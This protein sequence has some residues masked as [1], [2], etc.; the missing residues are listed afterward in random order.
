[1]SA[2]QLARQRSISSNSR[3]TPSSQSKGKGPVVT[4]PFEPCAATASLFLYAQA[5]SISCLHHDT[6]AIERRFEKHVDNVQLI[7]V[8]NVSERGAGRLVVSYDVGRTA[9]VW[10]LFSGQEIARFSSFEHITV[11]AWMRNG[12]VAFGNTKGE[13]ILFE[14][15]TSEHISAKTIYD[16]ITALAPSADCKV[17]AIGYNNGSIL[18][19]T[20]QP[21]FTILH[22]LTT[23]RA[24]SPIAALAWHA[25]SSKQKSDMLATQ[26]CDGDLRVWS[27]AKPPTGDAPRVIRA[28]RRSEN[29]SPGR[30]WISWSKN[31]RIVQYS[32]RETWSWD[33]RTKHVT[34]ET[35]PTVEE[36]RGL[37]GYGPT[38]TLFTLG[39]NHTIQQYDLE[40]PQMVANVH[41]PPMTV[42]PTPPEELNQQLGLS[43]SESEEDIP[44]PITKATRYVKTL[45][46][47]RVERAQSGSPRSTRSRTESQSSQASSTQER[48][49]KLGQMVRTDGNSTVFS[50][51]TQSQISRDPALTSSSMTYPSSIQSP[52]STKSTR[53]GSRLKQEVLPSPEERPVK[54]LFPYTRARLSDIP[55]KPPRAFDEVNLTPDDLRR[56]M[57]SVV[58]GWNE[59]IRDLIRDE[60]SHHSVGSQSSVLLSRWLDDDPDQMAS[61][62]GAG[63]TPSSLDWMMLALSGIGN[64]AQSKK[65]GQAFV[66]KMLAKG[67]IHAAATILL[68]LGDYN[69]A[70]EVYVTRNHFMEAILLTCLLM[71]QNWQ[72]VSFLVR[73][74]GKHV[75]EN[76]EQHLAIRCFS[77]T[78]VEP[79][80]PWTSPTAQMAAKFT[81]HTYASHGPDAGQIL[82]LRHD[83]LEAPTP[84]AMGAPQPSIKSSLPSR[85]TAKNQ[86]LKLITS[87][88]PQSQGHYRF[89]GLKS[90]DRTPTNAPG[91]T[92]IAESAIGESAMT[93]GGLGSYRLNNVRSIN[94]VLSSRTA[95]PGG[96]SR[97]RLP[98]IGETPIDV[99]PPAFP[100]FSAPK[101]L[102]TPVDSGSDK[103]KEALLAQ[104]EAQPAARLT[105]DLPPLLTSAKYEPSHKTPSTETPLT[106]VAPATM[107]KLQPAQRPPSPPHGIFDVWKEESRG[108]NGSRD[109]KPDGLSILW[110][111][112]EQT[113]NEA[114]TDQLASIA[115][116]LER[117]DTAGTYIDTHSEM[118]SPPT[119]GHSYRSLKSPSISGR[120]IDQYIS[121]LEE[122]QY[123]TKHHRSHRTGSQDRSHGKD[124]D[125]KRSKHRAR[126]PSEED[127]GRRRVIP[128]AKRSPSSPVPMSPDDMN[129]YNA[130]V[131]SFD[132]VLQ[133]RSEAGSVNPERTR[134][135]S[136]GGKLRSG[137]KTSEGHRHRHRSTSRHKEGRKSRPSSRAVSRRHSPDA[138]YESRGRTRSKAKR[139]QSGLGS[140]TSPLPMSPSGSDR[141]RFPEADSALR[142]VSSDRQRLHGRQRST[143]RS[144]SR[145]PERGTSTRRDA[146]PD[147]RKAARPRSRPR[148]SSRQAQ[149]REREPG[150]IRKSSLA[151]RNEVSSRSRRREPS[152]D[153]RDRE[154]LPPGPLPNSRAAQ[155]SE[156][157]L[158]MRAASNPQYAADRRRKELAAAE[159]EAR[160]LSLARR[161]SAPSIPL[162]GQ[163]MLPIHAKSRSTGG[164]HPLMRSHTDD[165]V[166]LTQSNTFAGRMHAKHSP[167]DPSTCDATSPSKSTL[168]SRMGLPPTPRA[169]RHP[170]LSPPSAEDPVP[171]LPRNTMM[172]SNDVY[173]PE[174][175][176][177][178]PRSM[179]A[180]VPEYGS[181]PIP[182]DLPAHPAFDRRLPSSRSSSKNRDGA[183]SPIGSRRP[184]PS[185]E[186]LRI[187]PGEENSNGRVITT[188]VEVPPVLPELKHLA[189]PP[190]PPPAPS[191]SRHSP[192][193]HDGDVVTVRWPDPSLLNEMPVPMTAPAI[194]TSSLEN[195][196]VRHRRGRSI[197][198]NFAVKIRSITTRLRSTSRGRNTKSPQ[199]E[200]ETASPYESLPVH[201]DFG[202][203]AT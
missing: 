175:F 93:P 162:P 181:P 3:P 51:A 37:S 112:A 57:L 151:Y 80:E 137:S 196:Q 101:A 4:Q 91:I 106:A 122:A 203:A 183:F 100:K 153:R 180:P 132:S 71:P 134:A 31:G 142:F 125:R 202:M 121:S 168:N 127:R 26:T 129:M 192:I 140:P 19:A 47:A 70:I 116:G 158:E 10:D 35:V 15:S 88:G 43:A 166:T 195:G 182:A 49:E 150:L 25:S 5:T 63:G 61:M 172:L 50:L 92:P 114:Q 187:S 179:S 110:P 136:S 95:T 109:R 115:A 94:N 97:Q 103:E 65:I 157:D 1:M 83:F 131:E 130:S 56:Q 184:D 67:D 8:D 54:E 48:H 117:S 111:P 191:M 99:N 200:E 62:M 28:L 22:T 12:N 29:F 89:P 145:R 30:N 123:Y 2:S 190:P 55:Y 186:R 78:G 147:R 167:S 198:E 27:V 59:D 41:Y 11:A 14:P 120:S 45:E 139:E 113:M 171:D 58:F 6:L 201:A 46:A 90:D 185:R 66:E 9:I 38:A 32:E 156:H 105:T 76:S 72:R 118:T 193:V 108:R 104:N 176:Q 18:L 68:S 165:S 85:M 144:T 17:Y 152:S 82:G 87:F 178:F 23:Q 16:P 128:A 197:N 189:S 126:A 199:T 81:Q 154:D 96:F 69:D 98:S 138:F 148:S 20:L 174:T 169:M 79:S 77:C 177:D 21:A 124:G 64:Q 33:V 42:P 149:D 86:A 74:W 194:P 24:P 163:H 36:V 53:K 34:Y 160:R 146:S 159:L 170:A 7:C 52:V 173:Q 155:F 73:E 39:P 119:T 143:S 133:S 44:S 141:P 60:Q 135:K 161:P 75:V 107:I 102:P 84:V 13:V 40:R 164:A 188:N